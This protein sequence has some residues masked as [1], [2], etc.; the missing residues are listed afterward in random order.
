MSLDA[1]RPHNRVESVAGPCRS[2]GL[3]VEGLVDQRTHQIEPAA[4]ALIEATERPIEVL[5][6]RLADLACQTRGQV[7][8]V[9]AHRQSHQL[10]ADPS[11][12]LSVT[13]VTLFF[14]RAT[15]GAQR[16][17]DIVLVVVGEPDRGSVFARPRVYIYLG[18]CVFH[19]HLSLFCRIDIG[20][21]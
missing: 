13:E 3:V 18:I 19:F 6:D 20:V 17:P 12:A 16:E 14:V 7:D 15:D 9:V 1:T 8:V 21:V 2:G 10:D 11:S 5:H 4:P